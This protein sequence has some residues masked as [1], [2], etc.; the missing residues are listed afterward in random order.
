MDI[1]LEGLPLKSQ[2][3]LERIIKDAKWQVDFY[4]RQV[5]EAQD[6][7]YSRE[8]ALEALQAELDDTQS[9]YAHPQL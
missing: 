9:D 4:K 7:L 3:D 5:Q 2:A 6:N 8:L 1:E